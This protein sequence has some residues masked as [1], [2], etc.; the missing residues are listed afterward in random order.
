MNLLDYI[1]IIILLICA[2]MGFKKGLI[3]S[4][5]AFA[6][7]LLVIILAFYLKNP[8]STLLYEHLPFFASKN[9]GVIN[10]LVYEGI[11]Y[12]ITLSILAAI[13]GIIIKISGL[14][15]K[16]VN[17]TVILTLPSKLLGALVGF[18]EGYILAFLIIFIISL[19]IPSSSLYKNSKY[20]DMIIT[21][22]P[23][24]SLIFKNTYN[25]VNEVYDICKEYEDNKDKTMANLDGLN[26]LL[27][28]EIIMPS[29]AQKLIDSGKISTPGA[30]EIVDKYKEKNLWLN[31]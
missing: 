7:T 13:L 2:L 27:K 26:I 3:N 14:F 22:T 15:N 9:I 17:A 21:K 19:I 8:I 1:V 29:S 4:V 30:E 5:V 23:G 31:T 11:S 10:I 18:I 20:S 24:I 28:Y 16:L 6:G 12:L 25:A